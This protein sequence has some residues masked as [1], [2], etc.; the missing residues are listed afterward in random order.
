MASRTARSNDS[1][2]PSTTSRA[3]Q[4]KNTSAATAAPYPMAGL[5]FNGLFPPEQ[6]LETL[7]DIAHHQACALRVGVQTI[8]LHQVGVA[9][10]TGQQKRD[11]WRFVTRCQRGEQ[12]IEFSDVLRAVVGRQ[13]DSGQNYMCAVLLERFDH[14]REV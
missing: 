9:R 7:P 11:Q 1:V 6:R 4:P 12:G 2:R 13:R 3:S 5:R 14:L 8:G 10:H